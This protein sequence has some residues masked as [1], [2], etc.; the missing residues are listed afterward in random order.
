[1]QNRKKHFTITLFLLSVYICRQTTKFRRTYYPHLRILCNFLFV[2]TKMCVLK[3]P[4][5]WSKY[6]IIAVSMPLYFLFFYFLL[7]CL[8]FL[9]YSFTSLHAI[10]PPFLIFISPPLLCFLFSLQISSL[11][12]SFCAPTAQLEPKL[13]HYLRFIDHSQ[14][15][16]HPHSRNP[17]NEW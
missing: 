12:F 4:S 9:I 14:L 5:K 1:M 6:S 11:P 2:F 16:T 3:L 15:D 10:S 8:F 7:P 13:P 17:L